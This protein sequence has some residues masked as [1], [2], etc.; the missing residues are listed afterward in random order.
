MQYLTISPNFFKTELNNYYLWQK[1]FWRELIQNSVDEKVTKININISQTDSNHPTNPHCVAICFQDNGAGMTKETLQNVY[2]QLGATTKEGTDT[3]G[4]HGR[5]RIITCFAHEAYQIETQDFICL[6]RGGSYSIQDSPTY[7]KGCTVTIYSKEDTAENFRN[8]LIEYLQ[9]CQLEACVTINLVPFSQWRHRRKVTRRLSFGE[10][11]TNQKTPHA[12]TIRVKGVAM[13][14][15][16]SPSKVGA[17]IEINPDISRSILTVSRDNLKYQPQ[18][19]LDHF[20]NEIAVDTNSLIRDKSVTKTEIYGSFRTILPQNITN[21][22]SE[23]TLEEDLFSLSPALIT[24]SSCPKVAPATNATT[25]LKEKDPDGLPYS[26]HYEDAPPHLL[27]AAKQFEKGLLS[28]KRKKLLSA[29]DTACKYI[30]E[31]LCEKTKQNIQYLPGF[32]F[33]PNLR[34]LH[35]QIN[36]PQGE[37][38]ILYFNPLT[39]T[40]NLAVKLTDVNTLYAIAA[41]ECAHIQYPFHNEDYAAALTELVEI[42]VTTLPALKKRIKAA[43][44]CG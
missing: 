44:P 26:I 36:T 15:K 23:T 32:V 7:H 29:W 33:S 14:E 37:A 16:Y 10:I 31:Y 17:I 38:H 43:S 21:R 13:F 19:E 1:A 39:K 24:A 4:G 22:A 8:H 2:F 41:H 40:G 11:H 27:R 35:Q 5:A 28:G 9:T 12:I 20:L 6:G 25:T 3:I 42:S 34:G 18:Q 30:L